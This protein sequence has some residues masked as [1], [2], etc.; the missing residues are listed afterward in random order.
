MDPDPINPAPENGSTLMHKQTAK[1]GLSELSF[2]FFKKGYEVGGI[3][4][5]RGRFNSGRVMVTGEN[6]YNQN[7]LC[8]HMNIFSEN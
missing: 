3:E 6:E 1:I 2:F 4:V 8:E 7:T 5:L